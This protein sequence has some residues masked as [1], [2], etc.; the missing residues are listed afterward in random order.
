MSAILKI[1]RRE[2]LKMTAAASLSAPLVF[3]AEGPA[4][5]GPSER[6]TLGFIG[7]GTQGRG[8]LHNF[9]NQQNTQVV[10]VCDV[11]TTRREHHRKSVD[12]FYAAKGNKEFKGCAEYKEF[13]ELI[14]RADI[15]AVVIATPDHWH[16][17]LAIP[18]CNAGQ[19]IYC[20]A[21]LP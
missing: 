15:D 19:D 21:P 6:I 20:Q 3:G 16:A 12:D 9:L 2:F 13:S 1:G 7:T 5:K 8:L 4:R 14:G 17:I 10:A 11:D 18:A